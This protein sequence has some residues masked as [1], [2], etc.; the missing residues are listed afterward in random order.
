MTRK[1]RIECR[2]QMRSQVVRVLSDMLKRHKYCEDYSSDMSVGDL[3]NEVSKLV[4]L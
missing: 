3:K 2:I 1:E 4:M